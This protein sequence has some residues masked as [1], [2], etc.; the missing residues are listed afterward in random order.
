MTPL[1]SAVFTGK[2]EVVRLL[3]KLGVS[4]EEKDEIRRIALLIT[5]LFFIWVIKFCLY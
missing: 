4:I 1:Q 5:V 2:E 3:V